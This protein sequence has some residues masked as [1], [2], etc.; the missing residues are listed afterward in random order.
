MHGTE[1]T[2]MFGRHRMHYDGE[3]S[4]HCISPYHENETEY[5][6]L[7]PSCILRE[8]LEASGSYY[9]NII[10]VLT[11]YLEVIMHTNK[12]ELKD[13]FYNGVNKEGGV[14]PEL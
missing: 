4:I 2:F 13:T 9:D 7:L 8:K 12:W 3:L 1:L 11:I 10:K 6:V 5:T 14:C